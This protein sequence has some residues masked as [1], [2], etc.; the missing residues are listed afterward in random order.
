MADMVGGVWEWT[1]STLPIRGLAPEQAGTP[2]EVRGGS[3]FSDPDRAVCR[4]SDGYPAV[5]AQQA[6]PDLGFRCCRGPKWVAPSEA[7]TPLVSCPSDMV[8]QNGFC[9]DRFEFPGTAGQPPLGQIDW[10][11]AQATCTDAG[12]RVCTEQEWSQACEGSSQRRWA[13][14]NDYPGDR[15]NIGRPP[16][17]GQPGEPEPVNPAGQ[18]TTP[19]GVHDLAGN[20]WE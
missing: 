9:I 5:G 19:E 15:C 4:P 1:D 12:K 17:S 14:G 7:P 13:T 20:V 10:S 8:A 6:M 2:H 11:Q 18:C 16:T 3:W